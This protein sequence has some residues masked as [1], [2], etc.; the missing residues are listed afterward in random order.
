MDKNI[1]FI[2]VIIIIVLIFVLW[3]GI[4][5]VFMTNRTTETQAT[6]VETKFANSNGTKFRNSKWALVSYT[7]GNNTVVSENRIQVSMYAKVGEKIQVRY[8]K[9]YPQRIATF[10]FKKLAIGILVVAIFIIVRLLF[11]KEILK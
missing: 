6:I 7:V 3:Q 9:N 2:N 11:Q 5:I 8:Y 4:Q 1:C 10:S